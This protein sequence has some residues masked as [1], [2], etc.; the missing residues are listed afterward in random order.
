[1]P[2]ALTRPLPSR[3]S[4]RHRHPAAHRSIERALGEEGFLWEGASVRGR[5][6]LQALSDGA[7][8]QP[9]LSVT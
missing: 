2:D 7:M 8:L 4:A 5:D 9:A 6:I 1:L 3:S